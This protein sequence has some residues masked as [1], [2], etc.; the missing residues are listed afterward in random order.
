M[1]AG[2]AENVA[3][4]IETILLCALKQAVEAAVAAA[5]RLK[6]KQ[7]RRFCILIELQWRLDTFCILIVELQWRLDT[8][9]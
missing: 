2:S 4:E 3:A 6:R 8:I 5:M 9:L 1:L 7:R